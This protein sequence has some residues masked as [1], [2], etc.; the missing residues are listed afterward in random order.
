[1]WLLLRHSGEILL[2]KF[3][4]IEKTK[5]KNKCTKSHLLAILGKFTPKTSKNSYQKD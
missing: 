1:M 5:L 2:A 3:N 4:R